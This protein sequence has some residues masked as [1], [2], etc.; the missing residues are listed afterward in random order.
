MLD[1]SDLDLAI[2]VSPI[3]IFGLIVV[4]VVAIFVYL[5]HKE[6]EELKCD[7]GEKVELINNQCLCVTPA[8][9]R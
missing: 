6:C 1:D 8:R 9:S 7:N 3:S 2:I 5:N 4:I